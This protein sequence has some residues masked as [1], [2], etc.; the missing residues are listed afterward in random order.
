MQGEMNF[1]SIRRWDFFAQWGCCQDVPAF[2]VSGVRKAPEPS[3]TFWSSMFL[4]EGTCWVDRSSEKLGLFCVSI[5]HP[6][7]PSPRRQ[8]RDLGLRQA[9]SYCNKGVPHKTAAGPQPTHQTWPLLPR[10]ERRPPERQR[11]GGDSSYLISPC[12]SSVFEGAAHTQEGN[13]GLQG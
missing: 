10:L 12:P 13:L 7:T 8:S 9:M 1:W 2:T 5:R 6:E 11:H 3:V 4:S